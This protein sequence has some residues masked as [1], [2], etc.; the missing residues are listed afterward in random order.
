M[1]VCS[2]HK[3]P[4]AGVGHKLASAYTSA[5]ESVLATDIGMDNGN[6]DGD[7]DEGIAHANGS[8]AMAKERKDM[9]QKKKKRKKGHIQQQGK[10][11]P[12]GRKCA[13]VGSG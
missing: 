11:R 2:K 12:T 7:D 9:H 3:P 10:G 4:K 5:L 6:G 8:R 13:N 1:P